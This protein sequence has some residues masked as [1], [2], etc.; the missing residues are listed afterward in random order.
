[1]AAGP[2]VR[3]DSSAYE[4]WT[5]PRFYDTLVS[6]LVVWGRDRDAAIDRMLR[7]LTEYKIA[8]IR[9]TIPVLL[10]VVGHA[11]FRAGRLSTGFLEHVMPELDARDPRLASI[12]VIAAVLAAHE[13]SEGAT[14][15]ST[16]PTAFVEAWRLGA[17]PGWG[18]R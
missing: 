10:H 2:W 7:A 11:D 3:D 6:K 15:A 14:L 13:R 5:V 8:G 1:V 12:A 16:P 18:P 9:T 4:G 17:R